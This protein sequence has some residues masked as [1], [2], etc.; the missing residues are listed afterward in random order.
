M[1]EMRPFPDQDAGARPPRGPHV[2]I[3]GGGASGVMMA[4]HLLSRPDTGFRVTIVEG[5]HMLGCGV[6]YSTTPRRG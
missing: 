2:L 6:A 5:R 1:T 4:A 3:I